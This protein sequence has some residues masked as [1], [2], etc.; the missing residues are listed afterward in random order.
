MHYKASV[1]YRLLRGLF[2]TVLPQFHHL[3]PFIIPLFS[4]TT[5][6]THKVLECV[7]CFI[8]FLNTKSYIS[9]L[10]THSLASIHPYCVTHYLYNPNY[11][12]Y[13][14][15]QK[16]IHFE[17]QKTLI[18]LDLFPKFASFACDLDGKCFNA[19]IIGLNFRGCLYS[20]FP[21]NQS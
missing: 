20:L 8:V 7:A 11:V 21:S 10:T 19:N 16:N 6:A 12:G 18:L 5:L 9:F 17:Y 13:S 14:F 2:F 15:F 4:G 1:V 3:E